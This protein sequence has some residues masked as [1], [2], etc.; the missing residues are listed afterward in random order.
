MIKSIFV[1]FYHKFGF[2]KPIYHIHLGG[3]GSGRSTQCQLLSI[4]SGLCHVSSGETLK[5]EIMSGTSHGKTLYD[6]I[7]IGECVPNA[8][9]A[10]VIKE[11]MLSKVS[12]KGYSVEVMN[13]SFC[14]LTLHYIC[15]LSY[16]ILVLLIPS[17]CLSS[18][19]RNGW[20]SNEFNTSRNFCTNDRASN[21]GNLPR[22]STSYHE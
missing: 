7:V 9:M 16:F 11:E 6:Y 14:L 21:Y 3:P 17:H 8:T 19:I 18:G 20:I 4:Y 10:G 22:R 13:S 15:A 1:I 5:R 12:G 2:C